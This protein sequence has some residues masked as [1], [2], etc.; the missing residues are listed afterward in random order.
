M[1]LY[2][3]NFTRFSNSGKFCSWCGIA[4]FPYQSGTSINGRTKVSPLANRK[5]KSLMHQAAIIAVQHDKELGD[6]FK[7]KTD[8][9]KNK[10]S[11]YNAVRA[12]LVARI[13][14]VVKRQQPFTD[15]Y[16]YAA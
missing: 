14:S 16:A 8:K 10:M 4:P 12:K 15:N 6:Y 2:T 11:V 13:F 1:L 5:M 3:G 9:G 7:R